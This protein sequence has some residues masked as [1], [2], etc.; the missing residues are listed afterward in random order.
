M[1]KYITDGLTAWEKK[2]NAAVENANK[3]IKA[4]ADKL[5][6]KCSSLGKGEEEEVDD[7]LAEAA[8]L[9]AGSKMDETAQTRSVVQ[10]ISRIYESAQ[11]HP[12]FDE[13]L[14]QDGK[15]AHSHFNPEYV[16]TKD[17]LKIIALAEENG[18][19]SMEPVEEAMAKA[20]TAA[21]NAKSMVDGDIKTT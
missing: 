17:L 9:D 20:T 12:K 7:L 21:A 15:P 1:S 16:D 8:E 14:L 2:A 13:L 6:K 4:A 10:A 5:G 18:H 11:K 3:K 19:F